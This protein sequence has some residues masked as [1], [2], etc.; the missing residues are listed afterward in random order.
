MTPADCGRTWSGAHHLNHQSSQEKQSNEWNLSWCH[1][2]KAR[3]IVQESA[4]GMTY[5]IWSEK[6]PTTPT[7]S[8]TQQQDLDPEHPPTKA[9]VLESQHILAIK[10]H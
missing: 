5:S 4:W 1:L 7:M 9:T 2:C 3:M 8:T 10:V 6:V